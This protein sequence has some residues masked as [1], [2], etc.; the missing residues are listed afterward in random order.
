MEG[1]S[2]TN[3][4]LGSTNELLKHH[5]PRSL[6]YTV[7]VVSQTWLIRSHK[8]LVPLDTITMARARA[9]GLCGFFLNSLN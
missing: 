8:T 3:G 6:R 1:V 7:A 4:A 9:E 5:G 2:L